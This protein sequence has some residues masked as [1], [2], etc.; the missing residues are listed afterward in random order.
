MANDLMI[1]VLMAPSYF[2]GETHISAVSDCGAKHSAAGHYKSGNKHKSKY[3]RFPT[4]MDKR[5]F[6]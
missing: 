4:V 3:I 5:F 2:F 1:S 6:L